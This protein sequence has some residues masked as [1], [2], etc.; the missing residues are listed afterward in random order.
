LEI[1]EEQKVFTTTEVLYNTE[2]A[3]WEVVLAEEQIRLAEQIKRQLDALYADLNNQYKAGIIYKNDV[4]RAK[5]QQNQ[6]ELSLTRARDALTFSKQKLAQI[7]GLPDSDG[8]TIADS[9]IGIF[10]MAQNNWD[11]EETFT[12]RSEIKIL[13]KSIESEKIAKEILKADLRPSINLGLDGFAAWGKQGI[14]P[15][16]N[17]NLIVSYY[18]V[19]S[20]SFPIFDGGRKRQKIKEQQHRIAAEEYQLKERQEQVSLEV[21]QAYLQLN[22]SVKHIDLS[23]LSIEQAEENLRLSYDRLKAG[24]IAGKDV[25]DAETIWQ[26]AHSN[27]IEAK[28]EYRINEAVLRKVLGEL[29]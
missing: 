8:F 2:T 20:L 25:L 19:L 22:Q 14:N 16:N 29:K 23:R 28:V 26:Q 1:Q 11:L 15:S 27:M 17:S 3:Y 7:A 21:Q 9:V 12:R 10:N 13:Q 18:G 5:V 24:T 6:N 4:L